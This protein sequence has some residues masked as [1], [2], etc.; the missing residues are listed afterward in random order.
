MIYE[1]SLLKPL[2]EFPF[3]SKVLHADNKKQKHTIFKSLSS[4]IYLI[5]N[6]IYPLNLD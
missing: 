6:I 4:F 1:G 5:K 3:L 2:K